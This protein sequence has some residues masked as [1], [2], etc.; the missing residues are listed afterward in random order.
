MPDAGPAPARRF[1]LLVFDWDGTLADSTAIIAASIQQA[2]CDLGLPVPAEVAARFVIGL[3][4]GDA[5]RQ[6]APTLAPAD[7]P[8]LSE[9]YREHY[10]AR[11]P[12]IPL[13]AGVREMLDE[14]DALGFLLAVATGKSR[15]GLTRA[16]SQQGLEARFV[17]S[18]CADEGFPKPHPDMLLALMERCGVGPAETLMIGDTSHDLELARNAG[19][20]AVAVTYGAHGAD[21]LAALSPLALVSSVAELHAWLK[22]NG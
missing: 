11:D 5:L 15:V 20:S 21:G 17:A 10:L 8:R 4:L 6:V 1:R 7:Y 9:R 19:A 16:L 18:R 3:G 12:E 14:L 13:F 22:A 2:C